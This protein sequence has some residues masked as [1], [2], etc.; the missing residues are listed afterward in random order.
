[1]RGKLGQTYHISTDDIKT[2]K[3]VIKIVCKISGRNFNNFVKNYHE[4]LGKD[5]L[6]YLN[7]NKLKRELN[8]KPKTSLEVGIK[9]TL[10]WID[11]NLELFKESEL[12]YKHKK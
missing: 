11:K 12:N 7:S 1:M 4:R 2:I 9:K 10:E 8:W 5:Y 6:Y 3:S